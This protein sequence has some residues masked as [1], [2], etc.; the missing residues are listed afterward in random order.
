MDHAKTKVVRTFFDLP[1]DAASDMESAEFLAGFPSGRVLEWSALLE[2]DRVL[3]IS[4]AGMG[5]TF[6]CQRAR[7]RLWE[8]GQAA[9]YIELST[10]VTDSIEDR[11]DNEEKKR[12][13]G[14]QAAQTERAVFFL[15]SIDE[16]RIT[17]AS[18]EQAIK[19]VANSLSG[20]LGRCTIVITTRPIPFDREIIGRYLPVPPKPV[21]EE[22]QEVAFA[23]IAMRVRKTKEVPAQASWRLV[24][25]TQ[26]REDQMRIMAA[27][28]GVNDVE[29]LFDEIGA[30]NA[31]DFARRPLDFLALCGDWNETG[32]IRRHRD[33]IHTA[34]EIRLRPN[35]KRNELVPLDP[36][37]AR[38]SAAR[39]ALAAL[40]G[41][42]FNIWHGDDADRASGDGAL[43]PTRILTNR[44]PDELDTL[45]ERALFGFA[46]YGRVRFYHRSCIEYLAAERLSYLI[47]KGLPTRKLIELLFA[48]SPE[49]RRIVRPA[50]RP[51]AAWLAANNDFVRQEVLKHEP[52]LLL[53]YGDPESL[54]L[55]LRRAA[56]AGYVAAFGKGG[57]RGQAVPALQVQRF[58]D[59]GLALD[60]ARHWDKGVEN[61]EVRETLLGLISAGKMV[62]NSDLAYSVAIDVDL[63]VGSRIAALVALSQIEDRRLLALLDD[64]S[65]AGSSWPSGLR[66]RAIIELF[67]SHMS[68]D[69]LIGALANHVPKKR[70][71][72]GPATHISNVISHS[73]LT[74]GQLAN[75]QRGIHALVAATASWNEAHY[76][77]RSAR[78]DLVPVL[79][80][81]GF[82]RLSGKDVD[83]DAVGAIALALLLA[84]GD[85]HSDHD[86]HLLRAELEVASEDVRSKVFWT[87]DAILRANNPKG[88]RDARWRVS[89]LRSVGGIHLNH[90]RDERWILAA[91]SDESRHLEERQLALEVAI[92]WTHQKAEPEVWIDH[93][94]SQT[95]GTLELIDRTSKFQEIYLAPP[96][97]NSWERRDA[98][99]REEAHRKEAKG[100][101]SWIQFHRELLTN[102]DDAFSP[103]RLANTR[104]NFWRVME[105][106]I[107][108]RSQAGWN[109]GFVERMLNKEL[110]DRFKVAF[111]ATWRDD[112]PSIRSERP[113]AEK[114]TYIT[115]WQMGLLGIYAEA[116]DP[117]WTSKLN[118]DEASL[119]CR[120]AL[121]DLNQL[122]AWLEQLTNRHPRAVDSI[123]GRELEDELC[124]G[125]ESHSMLLQYVRR[126]GDPVALLLL[127]R[128]RKWVKS[129][130]AAP[131]STRD[132]KIMD[133]AAEYLLAHGSTDDA[134]MLRVAAISAA[135]TSSN[136]ESLELWLPILGRIDAEAIVDTLERLAEHILP[137]K[138]SDFVRW[139]GILFGHHATMDLDAIRAR[140]ELLFRLVRLAIRHVRSQDDEPYTDE[141][142][143]GLRDEAEYARSMLT[144]AMLDARGVEA[145]KMKLSLASDPDVA[146]Y[147]DR[148]IAIGR[149]KLAEE[150]DFEILTEREV[151][152]LEQHFE[153]A[154]R[155]R[156][157][158]AQLLL[159]RLEDLDDLLRHDDTP[160]DLWFTIKKEF[161]L[162]REIAARLKNWAR[163]SYIV[164][165]EPVT[166]EEKETDLRLSSTAGS[167]EATI[168]LKIGE[169]WSFTALRKALHDQ[170]VAKYMAPENRRVGA[171]VIS[172]RGKKI[173]KA[174][175]NGA[176]IAFQDVMKRLNADAQELIATL[177][178]DA[179]VTVRG[180]YLG[181][182]V[183][184]EKSSASKLVKKASKTA[185]R[186][187]ATTGQGPNFRQPQTKRV[188]A[189]KAA[190]K[191]AT[192][193]STSLAKPSA[194]TTSSTHPKKSA[195]KKRALVTQP[196]ASRAANSSEVNKGSPTVAPVAKR[197]IKKEFPTSTKKTTAKK[198]AVKQSAARRAI[199][200]KNA[201]AK[202]MSAAKKPAR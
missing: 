46:N 65:S 140:P 36:T 2:S 5:K 180:L 181:P 162:R 130:L 33:Q 150:I 147:R 178:S 139:I 50:M 144:N 10:L 195:A 138:N 89:D 66:Q 135:T 92:L 141:R 40:L 164:S 17:R 176:P 70:S 148:I 102:T 112:R 109:R 7:R 22:E 182:V 45:L 69:Q 103:S 97:P 25:L 3:I 31:H 127:P 100:R 108:D 188:A 145:W 14:W 37:T 116:E 32:A 120:Y 134:E 11:F 125:T 175:E 198:M 35:K 21:V 68:I 143:R 179:F 19:S 136:R 193:E 57:W 146:G 165:Q 104:W 153:V 117:N 96:E 158:M 184:D 114:N 81:A 124:S 51:V 151:L 63:D 61:P 54:D 44:T 171:L 24:A 80:T 49:G 126:S 173:W 189:K 170:L 23:D 155:S 88:D 106:D 119:A 55:P 105:N 78:Q 199:E 43:D 98:K 72:L 77:M 110:A 56:L 200:E 129:V 73:L 166:G 93:L 18:F 152:Q 159:A 52:A 187:P 192:T 101:A 39:L 59:Q 91:I 177:G 201:T 34:I 123:I 16:F 83:Q 111:A 87:Q 84:R 12:F 64:M 13:A 99:R 95:S 115:R 137:F 94:L 58:A 60:I 190:P 79:L 161:L 4:E 113:D 48:P 172:W 122:P 185:G 160:R 168:E 76:H 86:A 42:K 9:F 197:S 156:R 82:Q 167:L 121:L 53:H 27:E 6:E 75:L 107:E 29:K 169:K 131:L 8:E 191:N 149:E 28:A 183:F 38:E 132:R 196:T 15:D 1:K 154:P 30:R 163:E 128:V 85:H 62:E 194:K 74:A 157:Q 133:P 67:P 174:P 90:E 202:K 142:E 118:E 186:S 41:R 71:N 20:H 26:L 47:D